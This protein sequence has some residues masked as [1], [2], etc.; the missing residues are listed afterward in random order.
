M[1]LRPGREVFHFVDPKIQKK[2]SIR[3][4]I[5]MSLPGDL[6]IT[7]VRMGMVYHSCSL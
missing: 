4:Q 6:G 7:V 3:L 5:T 1:I 2:S